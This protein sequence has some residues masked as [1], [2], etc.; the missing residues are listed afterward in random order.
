MEENIP[1]PSLLDRFLFFEFFGQVQ[2]VFFR[3]GLL[4]VSE[5]AVEGT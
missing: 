4:I 3:C 1:F 5:V 2:S